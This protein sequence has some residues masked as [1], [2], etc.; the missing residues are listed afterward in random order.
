VPPPSLRADATDTNAFLQAGFS[1]TTIWDGRESLNHVLMRRVL[2]PLYQSI[3]A[4]LFVALIGYYYG[5]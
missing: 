5:Y 1:T 4:P 2:E 3:I